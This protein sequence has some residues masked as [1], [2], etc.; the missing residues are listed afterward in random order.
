MTMR[1]CSL[2]AERA[3]CQRATGEQ[4]PPLPTPLPTADNLLPSHSCRFVDVPDNHQTDDDKTDEKVDRSAFAFQ[5][6]YLTPTSVGAGSSS[7]GGLRDDIKG[8]L[9][10]RTESKAGALELEKVKETNRALERAKELDVM[11]IK[12][13]SE[14]SAQASAQKA[15]AFQQKLMLAMMKKA[16]VDME[17]DE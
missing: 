3:R 2:N 14:A 10:G 16:G 7:S 11:A 17:M 1:S 6:P 15:Q 4:A 8:F 9:A 12:A 13:A 5:E